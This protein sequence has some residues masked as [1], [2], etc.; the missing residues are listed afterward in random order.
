MGRV[1]YFNWNSRAHAEYIIP[2]YIFH[3]IW[4]PVLTMSDQSI[5]VIENKKR[6]NAKILFHENYYVV[7]KKFIK[8]VS[9]KQLP[10][11]TFFRHNFV[12]YF[13]VSE[14]AIPTGNKDYELIS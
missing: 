3:A 1:E 2:T 12:G 9:E 11:V 13:I 14:F 7:T 10:S 6:R 5:F 4:N 8:W